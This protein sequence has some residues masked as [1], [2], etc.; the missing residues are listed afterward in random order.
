MR[1]SLS[2]LALSL[3]CT[4]TAAAQTGTLIV[5]NM[6]DNTATVLDVATRRTLGTLP[7]GEGPHEV[8]AS[9]DGRWAIVTNYGVRGKPGSTIT[10]ID[11]EHVAVARTIDLHEYQRPHG[12]AF[13]PGDTTL[14]VTS[15]VSKA[16]L[17]IDFRTGTVIKTLPTNGRTTHMLGLS[18]RGD[19]VVTSN[20]ADATISALPLSPPGE[21]SVFHVARQPEGIAISP[22]GNTAWVG[23][24]RDSVVL[25]IDTHT[26]AAIDTL[27]GFGLPYRMAVSPDGKRAVITD[28]VNAN[29]RVFDAVSRKERVSI[30]I[31]RDSLVEKPEVAGSPSPEGI[32]ISPDSRWA[33]VTLQGRNRVAMIDIERGTIVGL[34]PTG[35]WSDGIAYSRLTHAK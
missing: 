24:N 23:S 27:H 25:V 9:H 31:G 18:A 12:A 26:G 5:S 21:A 33:F 16:L 17:V 10:V 28:P 32:V 29:V 15:E 3:V 20:I 22:D 35:N 14:I 6:N 1:I 8:A 4:V 2:A 19:R 7:T 30:P 13:L 34:A 11:V